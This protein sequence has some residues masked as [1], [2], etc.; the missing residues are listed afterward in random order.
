MSTNI[1]D[2]Q[3]SFLWHGWADWFKVPIVGLFDIPV[4]KSPFPKSSIYNFGQ[5]TQNIYRGSEPRY[6]VDYKGLAQKYGI[7]RFIDLRQL[8]EIENTEGPGS[9]K[10]K[11]I[12]LPMPDKEY[13]LASTQNKLIKLINIL[14]DGK[15][16]Y[17]HCKGGRHRSGAVVAMYRRMYEGWDFDKAYKE[18]KKYDFYTAYGHKPIKEFV[19]DFYKHTAPYQKDVI[20]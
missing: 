14:A 16:T 5:V 3:R 11:V 15:I 6:L 1:K 19:E 2:G 9:Y 8:D 17:V 10:N 4:G 13:P 20:I 12:Y 18:M 7:E